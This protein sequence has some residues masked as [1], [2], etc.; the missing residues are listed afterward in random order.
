MRFD[1]GE[2]ASR[3]WI[4]L[5]LLSVAVVAGMSTWFSASAVVPQLETEW[6]LSTTAKAWI[7]IAVQ[8][9][10]VTGAVTS[11]L[12][13]VADL[14]QPRFVILVGS[15]GAALANALIVLANGP[16]VGIPLR[17]ATGFFMAGVYPP[18]FKVISTWF[19]EERGLAL[20][21][22]GG[23]IIMGNA[24]PHLVNGFGGVD[25]ELVIVA[26]S[27]ISAGGGLVA[28]AVTAGPF[29]FPRSVFDPRQIGRV[30]ANRGVR[31]ASIGYFGH[32]WE[33]FAMY[34][35]FLV[36]F[37]DHL[38]SHG[39]GTAAAAFV[40]FAVIAVGAAGSAIAGRVADRW[41]RTRTTS[42]LLAVSG[43][44]SVGIG[45]FWGGPTWLLVVIGLVWGLTVVADSP[46]FSAIVTEVGDQAYVGTALTM[47]V[48]VGFTITVVTIWLIPLLEAAVTWRWAFAVLA[49][50][51]AVGILAMQRLRSLPEAAAIAGGRG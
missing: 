5:I 8:L 24:M 14:I 21:V 25:W 22:I 1:G 32:M 6:G 40:T 18:A 23:A 39:E 13:N 10:F 9:G 51:P 44:C 30:F 11:A 42:L 43:S 46:Q 48:A 38:A 37:T 36:F 29:P 26:T 16:G 17:F 15:C 12:L 45:L 2:G 41:G 31:L 7:T 4:A 49:V 50:G 35:W 47:Q 3:R 27:L 33:L 28:L 34:A 19:L 20:G